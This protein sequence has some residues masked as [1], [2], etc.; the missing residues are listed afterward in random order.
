VSAE[1]T[2]V[3]PTRNRRPILEETL[4]SILGQRGVEVRVVVVDEQSTDDTPSYLAELAAA[5]PRVTFV[6]HEP[7][8]GVALARNAGLAQTTTPWVAFCDDDD[9]WAPDKVRSQ[10]DAIASVPGARWSCVG[11]VLFEVTSALI[12][13]QHAPESGDISRLL[14]VHNVVPAGG[15]G[16]LIETALVREVGGYDP[17]FTGCEDY[18]M[19]VKLG[20]AAPVASVDRPLV[21]YRVWPSTM[22]TDVRKM[23][24]GHQRVLERWQGDLDPAEHTE[25]AVA[26]DEYLAWCELRGGRRLGSLRRQV[27]I[28]CRRRAPRRVLSALLA[29]G[30]PTAVLAR[31]QRGAAAQIP[32]GWRDEVATWFSAMAVGA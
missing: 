24:T 28:A 3:V 29:A 19:S 6:R 22:S 25:A 10:L 8:K 11:S 4:D 7:P 1:V 20:L 14:R 13:H 21:A 31:Q 26:M 23:Q 30:A 16:I 32:Q 27:R 12:G 17:W 18:E 9:L 2:V 15:S 5:D